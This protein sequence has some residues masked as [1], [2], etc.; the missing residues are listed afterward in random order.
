MDAVGVSGAIMTARCCG[1]T[2]INQP[3]SGHSRYRTR[4]PASPTSRASERQPNALR[5][6]TKRK[7]RRFPTLLRLVL[8]ADLG[9][10]AVT[11]DP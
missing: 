6:T 7:W 8:R 10:I 2:R 5:I 4:P 11:H 1:L 3:G 9:Y